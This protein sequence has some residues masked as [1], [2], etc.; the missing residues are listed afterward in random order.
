MMLITSKTLLDIFTHFDYYSWVVLPLIIFLS[1][2]GDVS[3]GT[4]RH[5]FISKGYRRLVP[6]LGFFEVLIWIIVVAQVMKN[7]NNFACY[8]AFAGGFATGTYVGLRIEERLALGLQVIRIITH[9]NCEE[10]I[11]A[12]KK[13]NYGITVVDGHG[14]MGPVKMLFTIIKR[15]NVQSVVNII[16][17]YNPTAFYSVED[18][19]DTSQGVFKPSPT[20]SFSQIRQMFP[21]TKGK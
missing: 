13:E 18:I 19:K 6:F 9:Q 12:L 4:L 5:V 2:V 14:A 11:Q 10:L 15:K 8:L 20:D 3:L 16:H 1:R 21:V 17:Q 7:L